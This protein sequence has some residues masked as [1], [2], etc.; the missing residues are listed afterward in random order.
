[1]FSLKKEKDFE[2]EERF[3]SYLCNPDTHEK[4]Q[5]GEYYE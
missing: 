2:E 3:I 4:E 1:M 5:N